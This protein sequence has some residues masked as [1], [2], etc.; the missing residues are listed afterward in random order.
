M[1]DA[2]V[3]LRW[4]GMTEAQQAVAVEV[5]AVRA[6]LRRK[7][8]LAQAAYAQARMAAL[9]I[10]LERESE[11]FCP[12]RLLLMLPIKCAGCGALLDSYGNLRTRA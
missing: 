12:G 6:A 4:A 10:D 7:R 2:E 9:K 5:L 3:V 1:T 8:V 11:T